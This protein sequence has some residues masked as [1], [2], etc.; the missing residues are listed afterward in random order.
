MRAQE[1]RESEVTFVTAKL[2]NY[3]KLGKEDII[4]NYIVVVTRMTVHIP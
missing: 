1:H 3:I 2:P 4:E